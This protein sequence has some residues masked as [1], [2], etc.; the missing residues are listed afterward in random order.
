[1]DKVSKDKS[2]LFIIIGIV[3]IP[4]VHLISPLFYSDTLEYVAVEG[5]SI[6]GQGHNIYL[7]V[8][9]YFVAYFSA[10]IFLISGLVQKIKKYKQ[11]KK[12]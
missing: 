7:Q 8:L 11:N 4:L 9:P 3:V 1:M 6:V 5:G 10:P 2:T 12:V